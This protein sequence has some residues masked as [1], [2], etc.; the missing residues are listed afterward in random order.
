MKNRLYSKFLIV[1]G[2][3]GIACFI[4]ISTFGSHLIGQ[5]VTNSVSASLYKEAAKIAENQGSRYYKDK[6]SLSDTYETLKSLSNYQ[7]SQIWILGTTGDIL[8][9]TEM[10]L[11]EE[12]L[13]HI[14]HFDPLALGSDFYSTGRFFNYFD[15]EMLTVMMPITSNL[16]TRGYVAI[17]TDMDEIYRQRES[18]LA[19]VYLLLLVIYALFFLILFLFSVSVYRPLAKITTGA[20]E[21]ADGNL[22][23]NIPVRSND[24]MGYLASTLNYMSDELNKTNEYQ[25]KFVANISHDFRS[26]LTSIKGY[27]EAIKDGTIPQEMQGKYLDIVLFETERLNKLTKSMLTLNALDRKGQ[28]LDITSFDINAVIKNTAAAFEVICTSKRITIQLLLAAQTLYVSADIGKIQQVLYNLIDNAVKFSDKDSTI[29]VETTEKHGKVFVSIKDTGMGIPS[30]SLPKIWD[31]FYK[32]DASRGKDRKGTGLGL[33]I[34][35][36]IINAH[37]Q[38]INVISTE[39]VGTEFVFTLDKGKTPSIGSR[40]ASS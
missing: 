10:P 29:Y 32:T 25:H 40:G 4:L 12:H 31:R 33:S 9:N 7:N 11:D 18:I 37:N 35:K 28:F 1:Y 39:G 24:E 6:D 20:R 3:L 38:N 13:E 26:P 23:Y 27:V 8:L 14:D 21:Y 30:E 5:K 36:E 17:H 2:M 16:V 34:V 22:T 19:V 15:Q